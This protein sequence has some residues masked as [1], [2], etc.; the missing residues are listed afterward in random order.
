MNPVIC[1]FSVLHWHS[2]LLQLCEWRERSWSL[3]TSCAE[4]K[5]FTVK[6]QRN[7]LLC[8]LSRAFRKIPMVLSWRRT[9]LCKLCLKAFLSAARGPN[10]NSAQGEPVDS[11]LLLFNGKKEALNTN[12]SQWK[13]LK[14]SSKCHAV[15]SCSHTHLVPLNPF[16]ALSE[17]Q[18]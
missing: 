16:K 6:N 18:L 9:M 12:N 17:P 11:Q 7:A 10:C 15:L 13:Q 14:Q 4:L 1:T 3:F 8:L 2:T 5:V